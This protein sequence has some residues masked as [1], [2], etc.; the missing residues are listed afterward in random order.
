MKCYGFNEFV[1]N[2]IAYAKDKKSEI[3]ISIEA[4]NKKPVVGSGQYVYDRHYNLKSSSITMEFIAGGALADNKSDMAKDLKESADSLAVRLK[5][6]LP[7]YEIE[8][9]SNKVKLVSKD[10]K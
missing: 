9:T 1:D 8:N 6:A 10:L 3:S 4:K 5:R 2:L 7:D